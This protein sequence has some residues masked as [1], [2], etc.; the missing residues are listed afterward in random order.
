MDA[1]EK[2]FMM[3]DANEFM[4]ALG[5]LDEDPENAKNILLQLARKNPQEFLKRVQDFQKKHP[6]LSPIQTEQ[7]RKQIKNGKTIQA[8]KLFREF[9]GE[10]LKDAKYA[11]DEMRDQMKADGEL[12]Y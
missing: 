5:F 2:S 8:I 7:V 1:L 6:M 11:V 3:V 10:T 9:S 12:D 4:D